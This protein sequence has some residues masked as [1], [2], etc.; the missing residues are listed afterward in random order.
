MHTLAHTQVQNLQFVLALMASH[1]LFVQ[2][3]ILIRKFFDE[4]LFKIFPMI[5]N[6]IRLVEPLTLLIFLSSQLSSNF[7]HM[8]VS[9]ILIINSAL[10]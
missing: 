7:I 2:H 8:V 3:E 9:Y 4:S 10:K 6:P 5:L 1:R